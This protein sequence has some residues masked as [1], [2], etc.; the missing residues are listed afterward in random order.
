MNR[1]SFK[2]W[3]L[4]F[5]PKTLPASIAPVIVGS[6]LAGF[7]NTFQIIPA[8]IA[9]IC[10]MLLQIGVNLANDYYDYVK[11]TDTDERLGPTRVTKSNL[12]SARQ[13]KIV[14]YMVFLLAVLFGLYLIKIGGWPILI[15]GIVSIISAL[16][17]SGGPFPYGYRGLGDVFVFIFFGLIAVNGTFYVQA[18]T[19]NYVVFLS[20]LPVGFLITAI[21]VVNNLRDIPTDKK[22]GKHT[23]AVIMG[24]KNTKVEFLVLMT[25]SYLIPVILSVLKLIPV[26][27]ALLSLL[28]L[29]LAVKDIKFVFTRNGTELN[30]A[31]AKT[32]QIALLYCISF[33]IGVLL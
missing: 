23:L 7:Y 16:L 17:Y 3:W 15:I 31:L 10:S 8:V 4:A 5:R 9:G 6:A 33:S 20:S 2:L 29:P 32:A 14:T 19:F 27:G 24:E 26:W 30:K 18:L 1:N 13:V 28:S 25:V 22:T 11:G 21:L 12:I